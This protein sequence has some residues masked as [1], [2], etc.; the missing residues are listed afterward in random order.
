MKSTCPNCGV[1]MQQTRADGRCGACGKPLP[2]ELRGT[3]KADAMRIGKHEWAIE[4]ATVAACVLPVAEAQRSWGPHT[5]GLAW[6][7]DVRARPSR[8]EQ[9]MVGPRIYDQMFLAPAKSWRGLEGLPFWCASS[10]PDEPEG[11]CIC[12]H[13]HDEIQNATFAFGKRDGTR[14]RFTFTGEYLWFDMKPD[15]IFVDTWMEFTGVVTY[16]ASAEQAWNLVGQHLDGA[17]LR[18]ESD[19]PVDMTQGRFQFRFRPITIE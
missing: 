11:P 2:A 17:H 6:S 3:P 12:I 15:P 4:K 19:P 16:A 13:E 1:T 5:D 10:S 18:R 7:F 9:E 14:F 8:I